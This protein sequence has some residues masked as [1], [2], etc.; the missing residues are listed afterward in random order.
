MSLDASKPYI[1]DEDDTMSIGTIPDLPDFE[2]C[3]KKQ[4]I[5]GLSKVVSISVHF[6]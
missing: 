5:D 6:E 2:P 3:A 4:K 1:V